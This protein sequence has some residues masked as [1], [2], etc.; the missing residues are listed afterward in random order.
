MHPPSV[1]IYQYCP[2]FSQAFTNTVSVKHWTALWIFRIGFRRSLVIQ[3]RRVS[4]LSELERDCRRTTVGIKLLQLPEKTDWMISW[5]LFCLKINKSNL[6]KSLQMLFF[7]VSAEAGR[8][9][10]QECRERGTEEFCPYFWK[11]ELNVKT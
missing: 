11:N 1:F 9:R 5:A 6:N 4:C 7:P 8:V 3:F 2:A 10:R